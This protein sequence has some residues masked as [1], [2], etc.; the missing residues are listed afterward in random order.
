MARIIPAITARRLIIGPFAWLCLLAVAIAQ[1]PAP[2]A[3]ASEPYFDENYETVKN[4]LYKVPKTEDVDKRAELISQALRAARGIYSEFNRYIAHSS[5][6]AAQAKNG[7]YDG[8]RATAERME[9]YYLR[10]EIMLAV[11]QHQL[12]EG[13]MEIARQT[14]E[15]IKHPEFRDLALNEI[16][17]AWVAAGDYK[18]ALTLAEQNFGKGEHYLEAAAAA[19]ILQAEGGEQEE[20]QRLFKTALEIARGF[21]DYE[22]RARMLH[23]VDAAQ[24]KSGDLDAARRSL[25]EAYDQMKQLAPLTDEVEDDEGYVMVYDPIF[26]DLMPLAKPLSPAYEIAWTQILIGD[27]EGARKSVS[28]MREGGPRDKAMSRLEAAVIRSRT[29][30]DTKALFTSMKPATDSRNALEFIEAIAQW[31]V[32]RGDL[33]SAAKYARLASENFSEEQIWRAIRKQ[34]DA[35]QYTAAISTVLQIENALEDDWMLSM[36]SRIQGKAGDFETAVATGLKIKDAYRRGYQLMDLAQMQVKA[37]NTLAARGIYDLATEAYSDIDGGKR[38]RM[39][40]FIA[41]FR[42]QIDDIDGALATAKELPEGKPRNISLERVART[43]LARDYLDHASQAAA[44]ITDKKIRDK[45]FYAIS[46]K[47][48]TAGDY[49][50]SR[51]LVLDIDDKFQ[52]AVILAA[53]AKVHARTGALDD[54]MVALADIADDQPKHL[55]IALTAIALARMQAD[56][57][58]AA[59]EMASRIPEPASYVTTMAALAELQARKW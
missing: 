11:V 33:K 30:E 28:L 56:D 3:L 7:D 41:S 54:A 52:Q 45:T 17:L 18:T 14:A 21:E 50:A 24:A 36:I 27:F 19:A 40:G 46:R 58:V 6:G 49:A 42:A 34:E 23:H 29:I 51:R 48:F 4:L 57:L 20:A 37:D 16:S 59:Q 53:V 55:S 32:A 8:A 35:G 12:A 44:Q 15:S 13:E 5:I 26:G 47:Q 38:T 25:A 31:E 22:T 1:L 2:V 10:G 43:L 39:L 9:N